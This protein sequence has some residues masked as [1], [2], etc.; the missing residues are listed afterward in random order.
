MRAMS[1]ATLPLPTT[2]ARKPLK[3]YVRARSSGLALYQATNSG[4]EWLPGRYSWGI[5]MRR[6][7]A[8]PTA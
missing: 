5:P 6:S 1:I 8:A 4:P 7:A 3:S 2:T